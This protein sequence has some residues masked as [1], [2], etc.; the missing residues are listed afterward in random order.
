MEYGKHVTTEFGTY[1]IDKIGLEI[2]LGNVSSELMSRIDR[3]Q[4][5]LG[6]HYIGILHGDFQSGVSSRNAM[7]AKWYGYRMPKMRSGVIVEII[8]PGSKP[9]ALAKFDTDHNQVNKHFC[10]E[11]VGLRLWFNPNKHWG[12]PAIEKFLK[13]V[14]QLG[15]RALMKTWRL[16]RVDYAFDVPLNPFE[17]VLI[18]QKEESF[19]RG[20]RYYGIRQRTGYTRVYD[21]SKEAGLTEKLTRFE[22]EQHKGEDF[23]LDFPMLIGDLPR[24]YEWLKY[25]KFEYINECLADMDKRTRKKIKENCFQQ[26]PVDFSIFKRLLNEYVKEMRLD[27]A[28]FSAPESRRD[29]PAAW[30]LPIDFLERKFNFFSEVEENG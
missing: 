21:K 23:K 10:L 16:R 22:W 24:G 7:V 26:I 2:Y 11:G 3:A 6:A 27:P 29:L 14:D 5:N 20:T 1:S 4:M 25:V 8:Q 28:L 15:D 17:V 12:D 19:F 9:D 18:S 13:N 30:D